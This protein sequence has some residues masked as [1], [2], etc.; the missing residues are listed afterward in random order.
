MSWALLFNWSS[1]LIVWRTISL[2]NCVNRGTSKFWHCHRRQHASTE[3][4]L[5]NVPSSHSHGQID[6]RGQWLLQ[7]ISYVD[8]FGRSC[9]LRRQNCFSASLFSFEVEL[10]WREVCISFLSTILGRS[11]QPQLEIAGHHVSTP[12]NRGM[13]VLLLSPLSTYLAQDP[14]PQE[15]SNP[16]LRPGSSHQQWM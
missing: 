10:S 9:L 8:R 2:Y 4:G 13:S 3:G 6:I 14:P 15:R 12:G 1:I 11:R 16:Q 7:L 5:Q